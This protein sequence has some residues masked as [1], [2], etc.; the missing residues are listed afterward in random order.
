MFCASRS[1][2]QQWR[3]SWKRNSRSPAAA[4]CFLNCLRMLLG[5]S[6]VALPQP[7]R[8]CRRVE[9]FETLPPDRREEE[10][11]LLGREGLELVP[12]DA[13]T[14]HEWRDVARHHLPLQCLLERDAEDHQDILDAAGLSSRSALRLEEHLDMLRLEPRQLVS[15]ERAG[16]GGVCTLPGRRGPRWS[17]ARAQRS[18][19]PR[20]V[21]RPGRVR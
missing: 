10:A 11:R 5:S 3:R 2:A 16:Y 1:E 7:Q 12:L 9:C 13:R 21:V 19:A 17:G 15:P 8:E 14:V 4:S 6:G 20:R 18:G